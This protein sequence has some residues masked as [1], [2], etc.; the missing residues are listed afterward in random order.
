[1]ISVSWSKFHPGRVALH[2][3][4]A[5][6]DPAIQLLNQPVKDWM[7]RSSRGMT[8]VGLCENRRYSGLSRTTDSPEKLSQTGWSDA[9]SPAA[10]RLMFCMA[11]A[12]GC[13]R[14]GRKT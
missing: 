11:T 5:G 7:P 4:I 8:W 1:M 3:A 10:D 12:T 9:A 6:L 2:V 14:P 13:S